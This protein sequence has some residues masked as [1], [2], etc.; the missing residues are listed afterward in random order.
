M[1]QGLIIITGL[2]YAFIAVDQYFKGGL[3]QAIMFAGYAL[4][5]G[6]IYLTAK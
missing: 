4:A 5:N 2:I 6:G 3:G 1:S